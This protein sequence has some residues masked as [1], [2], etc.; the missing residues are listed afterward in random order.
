MVVGLSGLGLITNLDVIAA[1]LSFG[2]NSAGQFAAAA[3]L[4][5][6]VFLIPQAVSF[7][8]LPR[9]A[10][11]SAASGDT[12]M[13][14]AVGLAA[15]LVAGGLASLVIW[16][17]AEPLLRVTYGSGFTGSAEL[18]GAYAA[19]STLLGALIVVINHHLGRGADG[20]VWATG[21]LAVADAALLLAFHS[22]QWSIVAV[23]AVVGVSGLVL[24]ECMFIGT[25]HAIIPAA[26][27]AI[28]QVRQR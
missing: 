5:K 10:A 2:A 1:K 9:V 16:S 18:L 24:H 7:V 25:R 13:L 26:S 23:D 3:T 15:T 14:M 12:G 22:S 19:A 27:R 21:V 4:A 11:W 28:R 8:L 20:F 6:S 17:I